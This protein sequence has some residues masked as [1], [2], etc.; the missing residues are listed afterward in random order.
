MGDTQQGG[1]NLEF[2]EL[3][4]SGDPGSAWNWVGQD[5][6]GPGIKKGVPIKDSLFTFQQCRLLRLA[7]HS[8]VGRNAKVGVHPLLELAAAFISIAECHDRLAAGRLA[9]HSILEI[10]NGHLD[11][12][13]D[14]SGAGSPVDGEE[15][16][17]VHLL[18]SFLCSI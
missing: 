3:A 10:I 13:D 5:S 6:G 7:P 16:V 14:G 2:T 8:V 11:N 9:E 15:L 4:S 18:V 1:I 17:L 12:G